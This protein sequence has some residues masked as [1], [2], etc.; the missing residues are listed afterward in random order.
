MLKMWKGVVGW[1]ILVKG[2]FYKKIRMLGLG[3][4]VL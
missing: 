3:N 4:L 1:M 2:K